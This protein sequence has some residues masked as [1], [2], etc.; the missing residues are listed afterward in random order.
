[1][2]CHQIKR[3]NGNKLLKEY[4]HWIYFLKRQNYFRRIADGWARV[5]RLKHTKCAIFVHEFSLRHN[6]G[7]CGIVE[8]NCTN[9]ER[10][11]C[12]DEISIGE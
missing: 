10:K 11:M 12:A 1:M 4:L 5:G 9:F 2:R 8:R 7:N 6:C 3:K